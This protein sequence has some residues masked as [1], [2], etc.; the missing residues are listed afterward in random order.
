MTLLRLAVWGNSLSTLGS[1]VNPCQSTPPAPYSLFSIPLV[2]FVFVRTLS[3]WPSLL[4]TVGFGPISAAGSTRSLDEHLPTRLILF[5]STLVRRTP[6]W[7]FPSR[8]LQELL[9]HTI[10]IKLSLHIGFSASSLSVVPGSLLFISNTRNT[11]LILKVIW[12]NSIAYDRFSR[13]RICPSFFFKLSKV[14]PS[15]PESYTPDWLHN[16]AYSHRQQLKVR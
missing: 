4:I 2:T 13:T 6:Q 10:P 14:A 11:I 9:N 7:F 1:V 5:P 16:L 3:L 15:P 8:L 12:V